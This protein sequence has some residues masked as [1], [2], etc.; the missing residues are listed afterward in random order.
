MVKTHGPKMI[1]ILVLFVLS[2]FTGVFSIQTGW[3]NLKQ[4]KGLY[5]T[6][7]KSDFWYPGPPKE[8]FEDQNEELK[9]TFEQDASNRNID[10]RNILHLKHQEPFGNNFNRNPDRRNI[11]HLKHPGPFGSNFNR[12]DVDG[13][14]NKDRVFKK[15]RWPS[16]GSQ[17]PDSKII[18]NFNPYDYMVDRPVTQSPGTTAVVI[19]GM[20]TTFSPCEQSCPSTMQFDAVCG[21]NGVTYSNLAR[22]RCAVACGKR[23]RILHLGVCSNS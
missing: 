22:F 11:L 19:P 12:P 10:R 16:S 13:F 7:V 9:N 4:Y 20:A 1:W 17:V 23:V 21:D 3:K 5:R 6:S 8:E 15:Q 2:E 18:N 14:S